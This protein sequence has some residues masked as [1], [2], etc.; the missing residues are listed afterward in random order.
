VEDIQQTNKQTNKQTNTKTNKQTEKNTLYIDYVE[1]RYYIKF[2]TY[3]L[4]IL[5]YLSF[6]R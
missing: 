1:D 6:E 5:F 2:K 4:L 3:Y